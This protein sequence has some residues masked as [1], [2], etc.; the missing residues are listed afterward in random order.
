MSPGKPGQPCALTR[1][2]VSISSRMGT[3]S[4]IVYFGA[5]APTSHYNVKRK[6]RRPLDGL[7]EGASGLASAEGKRL[8]WEVSS[9]RQQQTRNVLLARDRS[10]KQCVARK[11]GSQ[12]EFSGLSRWRR[13]KTCEPNLRSLS[14]RLEL[15]GDAGCRAEAGLPMAIGR[16]PDRAGAFAS[17]KRFARVR[18]D[19]GGN[20][21]KSRRTSAN[22]ACRMGR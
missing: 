15:P 9:K 6:R 19:G 2:F 7:D 3:S 17:S 22:Y 11:C 21:N 10:G 5:F 1:S 4:M 14:G 8:P 18:P 16:R 13:V 20:G 12:D